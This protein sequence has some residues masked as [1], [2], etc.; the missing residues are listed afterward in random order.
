MN[1]EVTLWGSVCDVFG[2]A[3]KTVTQGEIKSQS[4]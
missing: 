3:K 4:S 1:H 2:G